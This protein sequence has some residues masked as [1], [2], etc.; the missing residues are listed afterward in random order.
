MGRFELVVERFPAQAP[1]E[2]SGAPE[3]D[4]EQVPAAEPARKGGKLRSE[5]GPR[6]LLLQVM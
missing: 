6:N 3:L 2:E 5:S 1:R 4:P